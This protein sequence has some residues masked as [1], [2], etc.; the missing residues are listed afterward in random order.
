VSAKAKGAPR[1][2]IRDLETRKLVKTIVLSGGSRHIG[3]KTLAGVYRN[4]GDGYYAVLKCVDK[5]RC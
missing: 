4:L 3:E 1:I 5:V 2:E